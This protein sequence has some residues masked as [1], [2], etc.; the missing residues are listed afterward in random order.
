MMFTGLR[1]GEVIALKW[2]HIDM[3]NKVISV[4]DN[5]ISYYEHGKIQR[6]YD[7]PPKTPSSIREIPMN[8]IAY[9]ILLEQQKSR[10]TTDPEFVFVS[11]SKKRLTHHHVINNL[12]YHADIIR[13][14]KYDENFPNITSHWFRHTFVTMCI[15]QG[16]SP[17]AIQSYT[18][19]VNFM[20]IYSHLSANIAKEEMNKLNILK[21]KLA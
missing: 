18:G 19:H 12:T 14:E 5:Y 20:D 11:R 13:K 9:N 10:S 2:K 4:R 1:V 7:A 8:D 21:S 6:E 16:I 3:N 17:K 15:E